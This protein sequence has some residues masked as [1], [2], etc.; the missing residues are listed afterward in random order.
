MSLAPLFAAMT[1]LRPSP[2]MSAMKTRSHD[3]RPCVIGGTRLGQ[4]PARADE[5]LPGLLK[6]VRCASSFAVTRSGH[7]SPSTSPIATSS[8]APTICPEAMV[9]SVH[10]SGSAV[11]KA[12][13]RW[14]E[15]SCT[16]TISRNPSRS[17]SAIWR[18][19][20]PR[21]G[22]P[23]R[24]SSSI[25]CSRQEI[26]SP[27]RVRALL[28]VSATVSCAVS[29]PATGTHRAAN[30]PS[31]T[32]LEIRP[33]PPGIKEPRSLARSLG[34]WRCLR[35]YAAKQVHNA[36]NPRRRRYSRRSASLQTAGFRHRQRRTYRSGSRR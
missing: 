34:C 35:G 27:E 8:I 7:P 2:S 9:A 6:N 20:P 17:I 11:P 21:S 26:K 5:L 30:K 24:S 28:G 22:I 16:E 3:P 32:A 33:A 29:V 25:R 4:A 12:M 13:R 19:S 15:S 23:A 10:R 36:R 14:F 1:S 31:N 18:P